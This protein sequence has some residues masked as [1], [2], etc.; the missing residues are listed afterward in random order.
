MGIETDFY[1]NVNSIG[2]KY[3]AFEMTSLIGSAYRGIVNAKLHNGEG[4]YSPFYEY[5]Y[6]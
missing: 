4:C 3:R 5:G 6:A 1:K 2:N